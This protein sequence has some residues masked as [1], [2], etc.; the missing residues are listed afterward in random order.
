MHGRVASRQWRHCQAGSSRAMTSRAPGSRD[1]I[2][3]VLSPC[4]SLRPTRFASR[5][6]TALAHMLTVSDRSAAGVWY[7]MPAT[8]GIR[9]DPLYPEMGTSI[10]RIYSNN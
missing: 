4:V 9:V 3:R 8:S 7:Q 2:N 1:G 6:S 5:T 10:V